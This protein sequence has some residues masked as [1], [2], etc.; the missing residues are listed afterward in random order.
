LQTGILQVSAPSGFTQSDFDVFTSATADVLSPLPT[1]S[2]NSLVKIAFASV[3]YNT[4][5]PAVDWHVEENGAS[6]IT[7][8]S[9]ASLTNLG[10]GG[11]TDSV[12][13]V[14]VTYTY[15]SPILGF[16]LTAPTYTISASSYNRPR[17]VTCV[18]TSQNAVNSQTNLNQCP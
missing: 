7:A 12:I 18:P 14:V 8:A 1:G 6:P 16:V 11:T 5:S 3:T 4:G 13:V 2:N 10:T 9:V 17:Y 15:T